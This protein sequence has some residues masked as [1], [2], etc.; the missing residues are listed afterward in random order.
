MRSR[1]THGL[2]YAAIRPIPSGTRA[3]ADVESIGSVVDVAPCATWA[4][5]DKPLRHKVQPLTLSLLGLALAVFFWGVEYKVSLYHP[6]TNHTARMVVAKLWVGPRKAA[7]AN[8]NCIKASAPGAPELHLLAGRCLT[9]PELN[10][11]ARGWESELLR[12][13]GFL[14]YQQAPRSPPAL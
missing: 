12:G 2:G 8:S 9:I 1:P 11:G 13:D 10:D 7:F 6:H 3:G 5:E 4:A 14:S